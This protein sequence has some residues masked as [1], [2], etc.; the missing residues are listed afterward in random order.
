MLG[1]VAGAQVTADAGTGYFINRAQTYLQTDQ[2]YFGLVVYAV[3]GLAADQVVRLLERVLLAWR[4][5]FEAS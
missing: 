1:L 4:P 3:L 5:G 2:V